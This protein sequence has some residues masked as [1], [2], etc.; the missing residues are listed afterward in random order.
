KGFPE[1][2]RETEDSINGFIREA[3]PAWKENYDP[4]I[5][6]LIKIAREQQANQ[7]TAAEVPA[8]DQG[9]PVELDP[10]TGLPK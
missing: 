6:E 3:E 5:T 1:I 4:L 10:K 7:Q 9:E 8:A 2:I